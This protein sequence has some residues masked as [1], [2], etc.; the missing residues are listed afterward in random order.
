MS[1]CIEAVLWTPKRGAAVQ[2]AQ[3]VGL[4]GPS[5]VGEFPDVD[6]AHIAKP[7]ERLWFGIACPLSINI[8]EGSTDPNVDRSTRRPGLGSMGFQALQQ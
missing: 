4:A 8:S 1:S 3:F 5:E 7:T 2:A 6:F